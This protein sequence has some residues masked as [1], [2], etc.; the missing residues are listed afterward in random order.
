MKRLFGIMLVVSLLAMAPR[1]FAD[2]PTRFEWP[3][4]TESLSGYCSFDVLIEPLSNNEKLTVFVDKEGIARLIMIT[5]VLKVRVTNVETG[6]SR[7]LNISGPGRIVP[8]ADGSLLVRN[9]GASL[10]WFPGVTSHLPKLAFTHGQV[11]YLI[12]PDWSAT[13]VGNRG[14]VNDLCAMLAG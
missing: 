4:M 6:L 13:V 8:Q 3:F 10:F 11:D 9:H 12:H 2:A 14:H 7:A 5:G 1:T